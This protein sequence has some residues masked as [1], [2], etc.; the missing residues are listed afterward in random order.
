MIRTVGP[1]ISLAT[2]VSLL[3]LAACGPDCEPAARDGEVVLEE[4]QL[5]DDGEAMRLQ[6][7]VDNGTGAALYVHD[8]ISRILYDGEGADLALT[9][10]APDPP[11]GIH[12]FGAELC[13]RRIPAGCACEI[14]RE[15]FREYTRLA[16][17]EDDE[18][19]FEVL[20]VYEANH[21]DLIVA[22]GDEPLD[23]GSEM[24]SRDD[25]AAWRDELQDQRLEADFDR[26]PGPLGDDLPDE[27]EPTACPWVLFP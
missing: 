21:V 23:P 3:P 18:V 25:Y 14:R 15:V 6:Y 24:M 7:R 11:D 5:L 10:A 13:F 12:V 9:L 19:A 27:T 1:G 8:G 4:P 26:S 17:S 22:W 2:L 20:S 16:E